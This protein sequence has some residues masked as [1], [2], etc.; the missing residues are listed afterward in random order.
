[1]RAGD[2]GWGSARDVMGR[3]YPECHS[4]S[5]FYDSRGEMLVAR[6]ARQRTAFSGRGKKSE[7]GCV[8]V[9]NGVKFGE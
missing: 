3:I 2:F 7:K 1:L 9:E 5:G 4:S 6:S 8:N